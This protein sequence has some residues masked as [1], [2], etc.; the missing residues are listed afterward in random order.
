MKVIFKHSDDPYEHMGITFINN[1]GKEI[2]SLSSHEEITSADIK[3]GMKLAYE[4]GK[5]GYS[6]DIEEI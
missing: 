4:A 1:E 3:L 2:H 5:N 6:F